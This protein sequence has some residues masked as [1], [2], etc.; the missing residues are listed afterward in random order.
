MD[1]HE[2]VI[3]PIREI[4]LPLAILLA[5]AACVGLVRS[6]FFPSVHA[7]SWQS[8]KPA[9][10]KQDRHYRIL[11]ENAEIRVFEVTLPPGSESFV[12]HEN[13]FLIVTPTASDIIM[14][15]ANEA[16]ALHSLVPSGE[17]RF[18]L[19]NSAQGLRNETRTEY[20][21]ITVEFLDPRV[22][23]DGY[24][25]ESGNWDYGP[26]IASSP[27]APQGHFINS[28]DLEKAVASDVQLLPGESLPASARPALLIAIT[29]LNFAAGRDRPFSL[30]PSQITWRESNGPAL[31][32]KGP[33]PAR[34]TLLEFK[35]A[36]ESY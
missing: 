35:G 5:F 22:T 30:Q 10:L 20:R 36:N 16:P 14:W 17:I 8:V 3:R 1:K 19:G 27:G 18:F 33:G 26:S 28:L 12:W 25:Y 2:R 13:N 6:A 32:N 7:R 9:D 15:K 4:L 21:N 23:N 29:T 31:V 24:R 34:F 11:M